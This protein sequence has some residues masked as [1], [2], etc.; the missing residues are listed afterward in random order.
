M[1]YLKLAT[2][3][4]L[5]AGIAGVA[6]CANPAAP[7]HYAAEQ[8]VL[9]L[10]QYFNGTVDAWGIVQDRSGTVIKRFKVVMTCNWEGDVGT[11]DEDFTYSDGTKQR[12]VWTVR[13]TGEGRFIGTADDVVGEAV[14]VASGNAL[15][16]KYVLAL[17]VNGK[18]YHVDFDDWMYLMD[19][20]VMLNRTQMS[21][22]GFGVG[23]I[24]LSFVKRPAAR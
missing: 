17:P 14:G 4:L 1:R 24:T 8:P 20:Q 5:I 9:D 16:W 12:R 11:L 7:S 10:K 15:Q 6:G 13:K 3:L 23:S 21:K 18:V 2:S 22:F 19:Q